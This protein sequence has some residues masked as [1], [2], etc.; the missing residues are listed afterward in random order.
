MLLKEEQRNLL[1]VCK[2]VAFCIHT[3]VQGPFTLAVATEI[4]ADMVFDEHRKGL[5]YESF[6]AWSKSKSVL[7]RKE[8][9]VRVCVRVCS[10]SYPFV[11]TEAPNREYSRLIHNW[12]SDH[13]RRTAPSESQPTHK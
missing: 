3:L 13:G 11:F 7:K 5:L 9:S 2:G 1:V 12:M 8:K 4:A 6:P 10:S